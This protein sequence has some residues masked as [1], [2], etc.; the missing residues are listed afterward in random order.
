MTVSWT[1]WNERC[2]VNFQNKKADLRDV[3]R[4]AISFADY[5][6]KLNLQNQLRSTNN[7]SPISQKLVWKPPVS[8]YFVI[9]CDASYNSNFGLTGV[10]LV[11][12]DFTCKWRGCSTK[13]YARIKNSE[14][15][16]CL[17]FFYVVNWSKELQHT[18]IVLETDL[19]GIENYINKAEPVIAWENEGIL[20]DA[21][22][23]LKSIPFWLCHYVPSYCNKPVDKLAKFN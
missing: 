20:L 18:H 9:N 23:V 8:P 21:L 7:P 17:A 13:C 11:L 19:Q 1:I 2:E 14:H 4:R 12:R 15:A 16:E 5:I 6:S 22:D 10:A 3:A